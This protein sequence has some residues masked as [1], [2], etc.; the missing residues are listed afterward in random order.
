MHLTI[1]SVSG[2]KFYPEYTKNGNSLVLDIQS[3]SR[4]IYFLILTGETA[5]YQLKLIKE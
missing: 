3:L 2:L 5:I 1:L 4:G